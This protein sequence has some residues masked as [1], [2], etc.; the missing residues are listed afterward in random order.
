M[1]NR[2]VMERFDSRFPLRT[3]ECQKYLHNFR[4]HILGSR[5]CVRSVTHLRI[6]LDE[7]TAH[8]LGRMVDLARRYASSAYDAECVEL[9]MREQL[10]L[11]PLSL[12]LADAARTAGTA[13]Q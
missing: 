12:S 7:A 13:A 9:A 6:G 4:V 8:S 1:G 10:A 11:P 5:G 2:P 3:F